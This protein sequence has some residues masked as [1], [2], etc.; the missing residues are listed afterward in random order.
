MT[1]RPDS[2]NLRAMHRAVYAMANELPDASVRTS[3]ILRAAAET[4]RRVLQQTRAS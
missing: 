2:E 3:E 4:C 1:S